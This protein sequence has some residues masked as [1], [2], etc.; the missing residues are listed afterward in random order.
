MSVPK[1]TI[2]TPFI[3]QEAGE[4][5]CK[6][7]EQLSQVAFAYFSFDTGMTYVV[8]QPDLSRAELHTLWTTIEDM[9]RHQGKDAFTQSSWWQEYVPQ[10]PPDRANG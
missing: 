2:E 8:C 5:F 9:K 6:A 4:T 7:I 1:L 10:I 3:N